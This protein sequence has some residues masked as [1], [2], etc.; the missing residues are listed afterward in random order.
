MKMPQQQKCFEAHFIQSQTDCL[1]NENVPSHYIGAKN[2][3]YLAW[4]QRFIERKN[5]ILS[6][7]SETMSLGTEL[8]KPATSF[9]VSFFIHQY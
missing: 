5:Y 6:K 1:E 8:A 9:L 2:V 7:P 4:R 3:R